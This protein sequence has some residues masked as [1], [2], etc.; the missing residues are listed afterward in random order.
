VDRASRIAAR[1]L[2]SSPVDL[3]RASL[4]VDDQ[5]MLVWSRSAPNANPCRGKEA[6]TRRPDGSVVISLRRNGV[7]W[8]LRAERAAWCVHHNELPAAGCVVDFVDGDARNFRRDN[9]FTRARRARS[10]GRRGGDRLARERDR[11]TLERLAANPDVTIAAIARAT[12]VGSSNVSRRL[13]RLAAFGLVKAVCV[14]GRSHWLLTEA[15]QTEAERVKTPAEIESA[16]EADLLVPYDLNGHAVRWV[17]PL[18][19]SIVA[20][21]GYCAYEKKPTLTGEVSGQQRSEQARETKR[22]L[23]M[24]LRQGRASVEAET[25]V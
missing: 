9:L 20:R 23:F 24:A 7:L 6:G 5:G 13:H 25:E 4:A 18:S 17:A 2:K 19:A 3:I 12:G 22:R 11:E 14:P 15:G 8:T 10:I 21:Y 1:G 16:L